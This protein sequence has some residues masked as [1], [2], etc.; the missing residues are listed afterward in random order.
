MKSKKID[1]FEFRL[2]FDTVDWTGRSNCDVKALLLPQRFCQW[3]RWVRHPSLTPQP[4]RFSRARRS[5]TCSSAHNLLWHNAHAFKRQQMLWKI[6]SINFVMA[7][8]TTKWWLVWCTL[9]SPSSVGVYLKYMIHRNNGERAHLRRSIWIGKSDF[10]KEKRSD[11]NEEQRRH[12]QNVELLYNLLNWLSCFHIEIDLCLP[13]Q[14]PVISN[15]K[16]FRNFCVFFAIENIRIICIYWLPIKT[17][18]KG[19]FLRRLLRW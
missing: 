9:C 12:G 6:L 19:I 14:N 3:H 17:V 2:H 11:N 16:A 4:A 7:A 5:G 1:V 13:D 10:T 15:Y 8:R 18:S